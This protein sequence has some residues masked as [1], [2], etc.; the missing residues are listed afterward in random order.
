MHILTGYDH[1]LFVG[2][3]VLAVG[4]FWDLVKVIGAFTLAHSISLAVSALDLFRLPGGVV[5]PMIAASIVVV[6]AE[7]VFWPVRSHGRGRLLIAFFFGL[8]HGLGFAGG[9]LEAMSDLNAAGTAVA[10]G[11]F[12]VGVE[13]GHQAVVLPAFSGLCLLRRATREDFRYDQLTRRY[14]SIVISSLGMVYLILA[15]RSMT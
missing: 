9:L 10:I 2:A 11:S 7:N 4:S 5:E 1:L 13:I 12:S 6:A 14:G 8:F 15:L 3:L